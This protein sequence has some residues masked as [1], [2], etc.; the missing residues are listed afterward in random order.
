MKMFKSICLGAFI[1]ACFTG[2]LT[3]CAP[4]KAPP[5]KPTLDKHIAAIM[6]R[7]YESYLGTISKGETLPLIFPDGTLLESRAEVAD[8]IQKWFAMPGWKT[9]MTPVSQI[10]GK[11]LAVVLLKTSYRDTPDGAD[12]YAY[13]T[14]TFQLQ[15]GQWRLVQDQN[16]RITTETGE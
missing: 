12:R 6:A 11:D 8:F 9:T 5:L 10:V 15:D 3:G 1:T 13:L 14:L 2:S 4:A 16:T 7:D